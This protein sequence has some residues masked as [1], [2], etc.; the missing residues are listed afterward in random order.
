MK[1]STERIVPLSAAL[2]A[3]VDHIEK[4]YHNQRTRDTYSTGFRSLDDMT[5]GFNRGDLV[6]VFSDTPNL[7]TAFL[8][9]SVHS[10]VSRDRI[11]ALFVSARHDESYVTTRLLGIE[12]GIREIELRSGMFQTDQFSALTAS[13]TVLY[14]A[15]LHIA[16]VNAVS[17]ED[18]IPILTQAETDNDDGVVGPVFIDAPENRWSDDTVLRS[19]RDSAVGHDR[20]IV[21]SSAATPDQRNEWRFDRWFDVILRVDPGE[22][23]SGLIQ[24]EI[25]KNRHGNVGTTYLSYDPQ[26]S[27]VHDIEDAPMSWMDLYRS[28]QTINGRHGETLRRLGEGAQ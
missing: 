6:V 7:I 22:P 2:K 27:L 18:I 1:R 16:S 4:R 23:G 3:T 14:D 24:V 11:P 21:L 25:L 9:S 10:L 12:S 15:P 20:P 26:R 28:L 13:A 19:L 8:L 17:L 5:G